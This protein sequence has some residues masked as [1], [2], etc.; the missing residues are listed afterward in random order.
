MRMKRSISRS[1]TAGAAVVGMLAMGACSTGTSDGGGTGGNSGDAEQ[2]ELVVWDWDSS[3]EGFSKALDVSDASF[4]AAHEGVTVKRN[5]VPFM[6]YSAAFQASMASGDAPCVVE[7]LAASMGPAVLYY[8]DDLMD[9][10]DRVTQEQ[11][12]NILGLEV[13][14]GGLNS[15]GNIYGLP[16][17][18]QPMV[19]FYNK[20][21]FEQA[22]LD[23]ETPPSSRAEFEAAASSLKA[24]GI[25]PFV[26]GNKDGGLEWWTSF[27]WTGFGTTDDAL[28]IANGDI[29]FSDPQ[30]SGVL[31]LYMDWLDKGYFNEG[32]KGGSLGEA[33][34]AFAAG[35]AAMFIGQGGGGYAS[36]PVFEPVLGDSLGMIYG[37][38]GESGTPNY[39]PG[40]PN[41]TWAV[42]K[43]C[44]MPETAWAYISHIA[45]EEGTKNFWNEGQLLPGWRTVGVGDNP[46]A[47]D[48]VEAWRNNPSQYAMHGLL[49]AE[50][51]TDLF[52]EIQR[53]LQGEISLDEALTT[54]DASM[55]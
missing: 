5:V 28:A 16:F 51:A 48:M 27:L 29:A 41:A 47:T 10:T 34:D 6:D 4:M 18:L 23:P 14:A 33:S 37:F 21:L 3:S 35:K 2:G 30:L 13:A 44:K 49:P 17:G 50:A 24:A 42:T 45:G 1:L 20:D 8:Q 54:A 9:L 43:D 39:L 11:R 26:S 53:A 38:G 46:R 40:G 19:M 55:K 22:G 25:T 32:V 31:S 15:S 12:D 7:L 52:R 36:L